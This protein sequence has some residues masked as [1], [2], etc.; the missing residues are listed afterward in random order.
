MKKYTAIFLPLLL[1]TT[2]LFKTATSMAQPY[3]FRHYQVE[4]GLSNNMVFCSV[5]DKN[6]FLWFGTKD[7]LNRF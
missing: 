6:G 7:G 1:A 5:Q 4:N 2:L 3:F